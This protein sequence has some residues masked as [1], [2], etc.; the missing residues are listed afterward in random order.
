[1]GDGDTIVVRI[2]SLQAERPVFPLQIRSRD[3]QFTMV[4]GSTEEEEGRR[5]IRP[6]SGSSI[7]SLL[8]SMGRL[9]A[10][11]QAVDERE[12]WVTSSRVRVSKPK[13]SHLFAF[14]QDRVRHSGCCMAPFLFL[15]TMHR[16]APY[17]YACTTPTL[18]SLRCAPSIWFRCGVACSMHSFLGKTRCEPDQK[19][20][21]RRFITP[22]CWQFPS[23]GS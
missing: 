12:L 17:F 15:G 13:V 18:A 11:G 1:M 19:L 3:N 22:D 16:H 6:S 8:L 23:T 2:E 21:R 10:R 4:H 20:G 9:H 7:A 14:A 5:I